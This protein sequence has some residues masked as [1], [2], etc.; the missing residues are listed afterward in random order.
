MLLSEIQSALETKGWYA[1]E[2]V[3]SKDFCLEMMSYMNDCIQLKDFTEAGLSNQQNKKLDSAIRKSKT[4]WIEKWD[5]NNSFKL[6]NSEFNLIMNSLNEFFFL[7]MKRFE[8]QLAIY[9]EGGFYKKHVDQH[10]EGNHRQLSSILYFNNC[11][12]GG[13]LLIYNKSD[14]NK[15]DEIIKPKEGTFIIFSSKDIYHEVKETNVT[16]YSLTT[17][18]RDDDE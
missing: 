11:A 16:R 5:E 8:S 10:R 4:H 2:N 17:W 12:D 1:K 13:E 18:F 14:K 9:E 6:L 3:F 7:S 15:V